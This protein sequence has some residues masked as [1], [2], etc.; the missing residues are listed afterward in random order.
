MEQHSVDGLAAGKWGVRKQRPVVL[1]LLHR[2]DRE[3]RQE[4]AQTR[5]ALRVEEQHVETWEA[6]TPL[7]ITLNFLTIFP[8]S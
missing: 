2:K 1:V 8:I 5:Y 4:T 6:I 7:L 3:D